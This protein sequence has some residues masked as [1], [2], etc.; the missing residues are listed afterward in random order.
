MSDLAT[1]QM[2]MTNLRVPPNS[3]EAESSILGALLLSNAA[4]DH[5]ANLLTD[6]D[7]YRYEHRLIFSAVAK[8]LT[9]GKPAD[10]LTVFERLQSEGKSDD[11]G[12]LGYL[13]KLAQYVPSAS[14]IRRYA[15]IVRERSLLRKAIAVSDELATSAFAQ[16]GKAPSD[17][18]D[19]ALNSLMRLQSTRGDQEPQ[20]VAAS[21]AGMIDEIQDLAD[22]KAQP[23]IQTPFPTYNR[24]TAGGLKPG[25]LVCIAA[26]PSVGKSSIALF[27]C[28]SLASNGLPAAF[29]SQEMSQH[30]QAQRVVANLGR[31]SLHAIQ[32][33]KMEQYDNW[34]RLTEAIEKT[35]AL[36]LYLSDQPA[37]S[38]GEIQA[39]TRKLVQRHGVKLVVI[40]YLQLCRIEGLK[41]AKRYEGIGEISR[42]LKQLAMQLK[43]TIVVLSQLNREVEKRPGGRPMLADLRECGDIEQDCD[44]VLLMAQVGP[45]E[46]G[47]LI[48]AEVAKCRGG[49]LGL[50]PMLFQGRHQH[51]C[52]C[53]INEQERKAAQ[54]RMKTPQISKDDEL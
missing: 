13:N 29:L 11:V 45:V 4:F 20:L 19:N 48:D 34:Q 36:P 12:G 27:L 43:I 10:V 32:T 47:M 53:A 52:E 31:L 18:I 42:G 8:L 54:A 14:N 3:L 15:E 39:K 44:V 28:T 35:N 30:E 24:M 17:V 26:R 33:G 1:G 7:F 51:W 46:N 23:G 37:L 41:G 9:T 38:L 2:A 50:V 21:I 40:D 6:D 25:Q 22:G 16:H 5:V 49:R